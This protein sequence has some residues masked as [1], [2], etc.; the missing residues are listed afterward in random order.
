LRTG[1]VRAVVFERLKSSTSD[2]VSEVEEGV[3]EYGGR[4]DRRVV[5]EAAMGVGAQRRGAGIIY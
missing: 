1:A 2:V 4:L 5:L 3:F